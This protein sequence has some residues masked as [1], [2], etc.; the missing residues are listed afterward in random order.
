M[1]SA[2]FTALCVEVICAV[3]NVAHLLEIYVMSHQF[4]VINLSLLSDKQAVTID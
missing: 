4:S 1:K 2:H 3:D